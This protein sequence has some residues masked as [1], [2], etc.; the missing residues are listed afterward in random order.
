MSKQG[1]LAAIDVLLNGL[2]L[3]SIVTPDAAYYPV[4]LIHA[5]YRRDSRQGVSLIVVQLW[6]QE[7]RQTAKS[8]AAT[9]QPDGSDP[10][11]Q[12][13][14]GVI[15]PTASQAAAVNQAPIQ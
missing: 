4:N 6:F 9:A 15:D 8:I 11:N 5:D 7:I 10:A 1:F 12:G 14:V 2:Q 3:C 13:Q